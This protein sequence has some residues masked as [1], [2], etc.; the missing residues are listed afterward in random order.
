MADYEY[1][2]PLDRLKEEDL[3]FHRALKSLQEELEAVDW[4]NQR[5]SAC[6]DESLKK[7]ILHNRNEEMEHAAMLL[8]WLRRHMPPW[9]KHLRQY[10]FTQSPIEE[11]EETAEGGPGKKMSDLGIGNLKKEKTS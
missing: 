1:H 3:N 7:I 9:E 10:L 8:E 4:Y 6:A 2:E 11:I 5:A